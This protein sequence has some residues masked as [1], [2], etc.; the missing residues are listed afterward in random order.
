M[1][2]S[3]HLVY[4]PTTNRAKWYLVPDLVFSEMQFLQKRKD[5]PKAQSGV[6]PPRK[7]RKQDR[8]RANEEEISAYFKSTRPALAEVD[9]NVSAKVNPSHCQGSV[10]PNLNHEGQRP[11]TDGSAKP[12]M[13]LPTK[14][15]LGFGGRGIEAPSTSYFGWSS[16]VRQPS[17][18]PAFQHAAAYIDIGELTRTQAQHASNTGVV[19]NNPSVRSPQINK[20]QKLA[21]A[22]SLA[23]NGESARQSKRRK[24]TTIEVDSERQGLRDG[25]SPISAARQAHSGKVDVP[26]VHVEGVPGAINH[27]STS[28]VYQG[29]SDIGEKHLSNQRNRRQYQQRSVRPSNS[30]KENSI[31]HTSSPLGNL[32]KYCDAAVSGPRPWQTPQHYE[33]RERL[34]LPNHHTDG[35]LYHTR[36]HGQQLQCEAGNLKQ[37][38]DGPQRIVP[39]EPYIESQWQESVRS[40]VDSY[41]EDTDEDEFGLE[42]AQNGDSIFDDCCVGNTAPAELNASGFG[43]LRAE[44]EALGAMQRV[45][46]ERRHDAEGKQGID[47]GEDEVFAGFWRPH[48]LY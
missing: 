33:A 30:N 29:T 36:M 12:T 5:A 24:V 45:A 7:S 4:A 40:H 10:V 34:I 31:P 41:L 9:G 48:K 19:S 21:Q 39:P 22:S 27:A 32:L 25:R 42:P 47:N 35:E 44:G 28:Q 11:T 17:H 43:R 8:A 46:T 23:P 26:P 37:L 1:H 13:E 38:G 3:S 18:T 2:N 20:Y 15:Y 16:S 14:P 6:D